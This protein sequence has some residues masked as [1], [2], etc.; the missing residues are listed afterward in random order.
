MYPNQDA[1]FERLETT[2]KLGLLSDYLVSWSGRSGKLKAKVT[3]WGKDGTPEDIVQH[4][5][6]RLLR[7]L[8]TDGQIYVAA[9]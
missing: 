5:I 2:K 1:I 4:Y 7:G 8:V 3:V 9:D 6:S